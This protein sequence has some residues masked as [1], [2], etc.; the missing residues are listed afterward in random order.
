MMINLMAAHLINFTGERDFGPLVDASL[1]FPSSAQIGATLCH[2]IFIVG[3]NVKEGIETFQVI[4]M[5]DNGLDSIEGSSSTTVIIVDD[6]DCKS[7][8]SILAKIIIIYM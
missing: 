4:F 6:M 7:A 2:T 1:Q 5:M 8:S 3:D